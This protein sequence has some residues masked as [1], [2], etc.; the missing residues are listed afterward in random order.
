MTETQAKSGNTGTPANPVDEEAAKS[1]PPATGRAAVGRATVP[2]DAPAPKFTRAPGMTPPPDKPAEG[3]DTADDAEP[4]KVEAP[5]AVGTAAPAPAR[6]STTQPIP[7]RTGQ[8]ALTGNTGTQPRV[9][10]NTGTQPRVTGNT[11]TQPRVT[12]ST[13]TQPR[14]T[15]TARPQQDGDRPG[16]PGRP[17]QGGGLPPGV[18]GAAAVGA[19]RVG[20]AVRAAR[21]S[22]SSAASRG[23]RRARLNLKRIDPWSVMK[24][25]FAVSVVLFIVVV[26]ATSVLYLAL[27]AMGVFTSVNDSLTDLVSAGGG[28]SASGFQITARGV[29]LS[30][31][32]IGLVNVVLFTALATLGAFVYN[33]CADLVGGIELTLAERD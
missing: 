15:G 20:E 32:L 13:G 1:G 7:A 21:T 5:S 30:S 24:F 27:D 3:K 16:A 28:Q 6:P 26:V 12:G 29:I 17:N 25:A 22:V 11:G 23:P 8:G 33:V 31:A 14:V 10:G 19:A 4:T 18:G 9:T 2:A